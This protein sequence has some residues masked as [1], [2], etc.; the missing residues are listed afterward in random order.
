[1]SFINK[2][3]RF[4]CTP[5][6]VEIRKQVHSVFTQHQRRLITITYLRID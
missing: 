3:K 4:I 5:Q 1:M 2:S 6:N